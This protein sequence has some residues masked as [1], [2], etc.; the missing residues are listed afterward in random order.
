[1]HDELSVYLII[2]VIM[3]SCFTLHEKQTVVQL[4]NSQP[5]KKPVNSF[6]YSQE[7]TTGAH[8][9]SPY[10]KSIFLLVKTGDGHWMQQVI[11]N[12]QNK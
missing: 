1:M 12:V 4:A 5:F 9:S 8:G 3:I 10:I 2:Q 11:W 6:A 7:P